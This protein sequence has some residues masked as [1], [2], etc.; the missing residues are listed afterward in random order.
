MCEKRFVVW[1]YKG[2]TYI[3]RVQMFFI[4]NKLKLEQLFDNW[5]ARASVDRIQ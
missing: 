5:Y 1:L 2:L 3:A 4:K